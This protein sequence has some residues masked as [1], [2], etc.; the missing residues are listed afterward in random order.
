[1]DDRTQEFKPLQPERKP[2]RLDISFDEAELTADVH[3][4]LEDT[5]R[6]KGEVY[7]SNPPQRTQ[8]I[9]HAAPPPQKPAKK[10]KHGFSAVMIL[11]LLSLCA[12]AVLSY[13]GVMGLRDIFAI[14]KDP[15]DTREVMVT[16]P[17]DLSTNEVID[18]LAAHNLIQQKTVSKLYSRFTYWLA[19]RNDEVQRAPLY[20]AS[21]YAINV[22]WGLEEMLDFFKP[23]RRTNE[24][25]SVTFPE[26][27]TVRQTMNRLAENRV[28]SLEGLRRT[29][30]NTEFDY[31]FLNALNDIDT[32]GRFYY[33]EGYLFPDTYD[34][35]VNENTGSVLRKF[36][37][38]FSKRWVDEY[39]AR[40]SEL[41]MT[42]D[43]VIILAS[44]I[45]MEAANKSQM[46]D[47]S[48]VLHNRLN[49]PSVFPRLECD[50]TRDYVMNN[51]AP[52]ME[53][54]S[55]AY[56]NELYNTYVCHGLPVGPICNPGVDAI[57][58]A[59]NPNRTDYYFFQ[60]DKNGKIY[61]SKT[62]EEH[63]RITANLV[64]QGLNQ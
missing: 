41:G 42:V 5:P 4:V 2:F 16:I 32:T 47:V 37:D 59:L 1:M 12:S 7:F 51:I 40:A 11:V 49:N 28:T 23:Q 38:N 9:A 61:L 50:A 57:E 14:G 34:F 30:Q 21:D 52:V 44:I 54:G 55:V 15:R 25:V 17:G 19:N 8:P 36:F 35:F 45:Q 33:Y 60:H 48:S 46:K 18:I 43:D 58:A 3:A 13:L 56:F 6:P 22:S 39:D 64:I 27:F 62:R 29:M 53:S 31:P 63:N 10:K 20:L 26:H 24:T